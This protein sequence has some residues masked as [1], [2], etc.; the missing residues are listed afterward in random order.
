[1][2]GLT[3]LRPPR[4]RC[5]RCSF[6]FELVY[7]VEPEDLIACPRCHVLIPVEYEH[8]DETRWAWAMRQPHGV[9]RRPDGDKGNRV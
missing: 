9:H 7:K 6:R 8:L 4:A 2:R 1:M 3:N 5:Q